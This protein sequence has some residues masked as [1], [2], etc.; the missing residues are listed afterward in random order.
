MY[1]KKSHRHGSDGAFGEEPLVLLELS[2][3]LVSGAA[4]ALVLVRAVLVG[5]QVPIPAADNVAVEVGVLEI[6]ALKR[7][8]LENK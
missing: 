5:G 3:A 6:T 4:V 1:I 8:D 7:V 2:V